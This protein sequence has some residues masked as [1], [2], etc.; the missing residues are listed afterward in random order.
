MTFQIHMLEP[1]LGVMVSG[2]EA[3]WEVIRFTAEPS[4]KSPPKKIK[5]PQRA[6]LSLPSCEDIAKDVRL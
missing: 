2:G 1:K 4:W 5:R 6:L 3:F